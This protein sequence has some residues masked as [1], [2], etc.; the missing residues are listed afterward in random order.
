MATAP[1]SLPVSAYKSSKKDEL[2]LMI[3]QSSKLS[4]LPAELRVMFGEAQHVLDFEMTPARK[5]GRED[6]QKVWDAL[7][8]KGYF[9]QLPPQEVEKFS[10]VAPPPERLDNIF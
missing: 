5:M 10:D 1:Q 7:Q 2:Y 8:Q 3:P 4:D 9:I 6:P